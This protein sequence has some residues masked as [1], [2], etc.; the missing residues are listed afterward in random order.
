MRLHLQGKRRVVQQL[1]HGSAS[2]PMLVH[3]HQGLCLRHVHVLGGKGLLQKALDHSHHVVRLIRRALAF[4]GTGMSHGLGLLRLVARLRRLGGMSRGSLLGCVKGCNGLGIRLRQGDRRLWR[5]LHLCL[6]IGGGSRILVAEDVLESPHLGAGGHRDA[7]TRLASCLRAK[8]HR[9]L[10]VSLS[11]SSKCKRDC[12]CQP[13]EDHVG[14]WGVRS[15]F[16]V[17]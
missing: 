3:E 7:G 14:R 11:G 15:R 8:L 16:S 12:A 5:L 4:R 10:A 2:S 17:Q 6:A 1:S 9:T 13:G